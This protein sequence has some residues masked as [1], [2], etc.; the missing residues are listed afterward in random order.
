MIVGSED[1]KEKSVIQ[2]N[3]ASTVT[4]VSTATGRITSS[5]AGT[6]PSRSLLNNDAVSPISDDSVPSP[7]GTPE[8]L[9]LEA[10][11]NQDTSLL[12]QSDFQ[13]QND[14]SNIMV[15]TMS[16]QPT[17]QNNQF[18]SNDQF[19]MVGNDS[20]P[21]VTS[22]APMNMGQTSL[23]TISELPPPPMMQGFPSLQTTNSQL[24][25]DQPIQGFL[26]DQSNLATSFV[27]LQQNATGLVNQFQ[28]GS[29]HMDLP[30]HDLQMQLQMSDSQI[31]TGASA[32]PTQD[33]SIAETVRPID[34]L[35]QLLNKG[36]KSKKD[37]HTS[38]SSDKDRSHSDRDRE[39]R[40]KEHGRHK[41]SSRRK[42]SL[43]RHHSTDM[44]EP[45][46]DRSESSYSSSKRSHHRRKSRGHSKEKHASHS[47][48]KA[49]RREGSVD[50]LDNDSSLES[51]LKSPKISR[52]YSNDMFGNSEDGKRGDQETL[53]ERSSSRTSSVITDSLDSKTLTIFDQRRN[54]RQLNKSEMGKD[55][56]RDG[57]QK[58]AP[59]KSESSQGNNAEA[60]ISDFNRQY[61]ANSDVFLQQQKSF[62]GQIP[63]QQTDLQAVPSTEPWTPTTSTPQKQVDF[64][65]DSRRSPTPEMDHYQ[66]DISM[67]Q[68]QQPHFIASTFQPAGNFG[69]VSIPQFDPQAN[70]LYSNANI[71][72]HVSM[73]NAPI[74]QAN[75]FHQDFSLD[76]QRD[77]SMQQQNVQ[78]A[79]FEMQPR[80][81]NQQPLLQQPDRQYF[82]ENRLNAR[83]SLLPSDQ[84]VNILPPS[85]DVRFRPVEPQQIS[86]MNFGLAEPVFQRSDIPAMQHPQSTFQPD[87]LLPRN[88][89]PALPIEEPFYNQMQ[90]RIRPDGPAMFPKHSNFRRDRLSPFAGN[91]DDFDRPE[92]QFSSTF[93]KQSSC[94]D[95]KPGDSEFVGRPSSES[96]TDN[97][98]NFQLGDQQALASRNQGTA[99]E[100]YQDHHSELGDFSKG[101]RH[102]NPNQTV[103]GDDIAQ[104][105]AFHRNINELNEPYNQHERESVRPRFPQ[106]NYPARNRLRHLGPNI[107]MRGPRPQRLSRPP[108]FQHQRPR[109]RPPAPRP[110]L[111]QGYMPRRPVF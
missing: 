20:W 35:S 4:P 54:E 46:S 7:E 56:P 8:G 75:S 30:Q 13:Q 60:G 40:S 87:Q 2:M 49:E 65:F 71:T 79:G 76:Q 18:L 111:P 91:Q 51:Y 95:E 28:I 50:N 62:E 92:N 32:T 82:Q 6:E 58:S 67:S 81:F 31:A 15:P 85:G 43:D 25:F 106:P 37:H 44:R 33:E 47:E 78:M 97:S 36:R 26:G 45:S 84:H 17:L 103:T 107:A 19:V 29:G 42:S 27:Q 57:S 5:L 66:V 1:Q 39:H 59:V 83:E 3:V 64:Y 55:L 94:E 74:S 9:V 93:Q 34:I 98:E 22:T 86:N 105:G 16:L 38:L 80:I 100:V 88:D 90:S 104:N 102:P 41:K 101:Q 48:D 12:S 99:S 21:L 108:G 61:S 89:R 73:P 52:L 109:F 53:D 14:M 96:H 72:T 24:S 70:V 77:L 11:D 10:D 23:G 63:L 69:P 68:A 110:R